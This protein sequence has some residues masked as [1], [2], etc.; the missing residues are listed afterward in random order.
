MSTPY[1]PIEER[2]AFGRVIRLWFRSNGWAQDVPH[3]FAKIVGTAGP[4][5][6]QVSTVMSGKLDPK[7]AFF[8]ALGAF[9]DAVARQAFPGITDR[10]L[11]DALKGAEPLCDDDGRPCTAPDFFALFTGLQPLPKRYASARTITPEDAK[12]IS[13]GHQEAFAQFASI[14]GISPKQA[15][16]DLRF[17]CDGVPSPQLSKLRDVLT[18]W[19]TWTPDDL[20]TMEEDGIDAV[21]AAIAQWKAQR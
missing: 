2:I 13:Q 15:W 18:G 12:A 5:N 14:H 16:D 11:L 10:K 19:D 3:K 20:E 21:S 4:W 17:H 8:V 9:N 6:S 1:E 7:P